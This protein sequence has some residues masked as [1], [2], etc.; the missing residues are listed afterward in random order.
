MCIKAWSLLFILHSFN[1]TDQSICVSITHRRFKSFRMW[2]CVVGQEGPNQ[3]KDPRTF[4]FAISSQSSWTENEDIT[5]L[6]NVRHMVPSHTSS[7]SHVPKD[8]NLEQHCCENLKSSITHCLQNKC[9]IALWYHYIHHINCPQFVT[10][11]CSSLWYENA[12]VITHTHTRTRARTCTRTHTHTTFQVL[13]CIYTIY[14][15]PPQN[16]CTCLY[17]LELSSV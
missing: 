9:S 15:I 16:L 5:I 6:W 14:L 17:S 12:S 2:C 8:W 13:G 4:I 7:H 10:M 1:S 11:N 3:L